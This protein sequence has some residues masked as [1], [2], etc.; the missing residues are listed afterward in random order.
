[1]TAVASRQHFMGRLLSIQAAAALS[2]FATLLLLVS[3]G[4]VLAQSRADLV[5]RADQMARN[6]LVLAQETVEVE[7]ARYDTRLQDLL[8]ILREPDPD[9]SI[10]FSAYGDNT[11]FGGQA[12]RNASGDILIVAADGTILNSSLPGLTARYQS[13]VPEVLSHSAVGVETL[14]AETV[15]IA[16]HMPIVA[17]MRRCHAAACGRTAAVIAMMPLTGILHVFDRLILGHDGVISLAGQDG[18][19]LARQPTRASAIGHGVIGQAEL[20]TLIRGTTLST[21]RASRIDNVV[22]RYTAGWVG[23]LP[24]IVSVGISTNDIAGDWLARAVVICVVVILLSAG[25]V[26]LTLLLAREVRRKTLAEREVLEAN[27]QL[28]ELARTDQ[29]TG[30]LNRRGFDENLAREWRRSRRAGLAISLLLLDADRFKSYNDRYG[31]QAGDRVLRMISDTM[32]GE[33]RRPNDVAARYGGEE[34][35][36]VLPDTDGVTAARIAEDIRAAVEAMAI[37]HIDN[38]GFVTVSIG[39]ASASPSREDPADAL[40]HV[41]DTALYASKHLGRNR[42]SVGIVNPQPASVTVPV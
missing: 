14:Y 19:L 36:I 41:A 11:L 42:V 3:C 33:I 18:L 34:F 24:F 12:A 13:L 28:G 31:H 17:L 21:Q 23:D 8:A 10:T 2:L 5:R 27:R 40:I 30:L 37:A 32:L 25:F 35:A 39:V 20:V 7:V 4:Y 16:P 6:V 29:L 9:G 22:R 26:A 1:M 15:W 38:N